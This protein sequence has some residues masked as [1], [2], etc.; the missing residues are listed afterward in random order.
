MNRARQQSENHAIGMVNTPPRQVKAA[1]QAK[2]FQGLFDGFD[3]FH[4]AEN[5]IYRRIFDKKHHTS[6]VASSN[7][8]LD[9]SD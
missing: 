9:E 8:S 6:K 4:H 3:H 5:L 2:F 1:A 7:M